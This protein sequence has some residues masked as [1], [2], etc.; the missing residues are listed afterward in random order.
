MRSLSALVLSLG[1]VAVPTGARQARPEAPAQAPP[2]E[3]IVRI[4]LEVV[5]VDAVVTDRDGRFVTDLE[6]KDFEILED[7]KP[8]PVTLC[9]YVRTADEDAAVAPGPAPAGPLRRESVRRTLAFVVDDLSLGFISTVRVRNLLTNFVDEQMRAGDLVAIVRTGAGLGSL[10]Q[11]T[12]D[13]RLL[14]SAIDRI[15][16]NLA[17]RGPL[18]SAFDLGP[19]P[20][21][22]G[23]AAG[24]RGLRPWPPSRGGLTR[25]TARQCRPV[26]PCWPP[27]PWA[28]FAT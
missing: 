10:Q 7:G 14:K 20:G 1:V 8:Q 2:R 4:S 28:P 24:G 15:R 18:L 26:R 22:P 16:Y 12:S 17:G 11:F 13:R 27:A 23:A 9:S 6:A 3:P 25:S 21:V 19:Q 5:Q